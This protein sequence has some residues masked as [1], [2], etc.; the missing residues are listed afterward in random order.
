MKTYTISRAN[1]SPLVLNVSTRD[2]AQTILTY[3]G[4]D[5]ELRRAGDWIE[6]YVSQFSRNSPCGGRPL[7]RSTIAGASE[8]EIYTKVVEHA[9][10]WGLWAETE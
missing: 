2:A 9:D 4:H 10:Y 8:D 7:I 1:G 6:L 5:Y 3:D